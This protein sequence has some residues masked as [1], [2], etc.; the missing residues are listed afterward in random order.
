ML[1]TPQERQ[2]IIDGCSGELFPATVQVGGEPFINLQLRKAEMCYP[3]E[4]PIL[5]GVLEKMR[6]LVERKSEVPRSHQDPFQ[7]VRYRPGDFFGWHMDG[8][9]RE[10]TFLVYLNDGYEGGETEFQGG[11]AHKGKA[12]EVLHFQKNLL[13]RAKAVTEGE[14]HVLICWVRSEPCP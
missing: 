1:F 12:G 2:E 3:E 4:I 6:D 8:V 14:K 11:L 10:Q 5:D 7:Y 9:G 13:H